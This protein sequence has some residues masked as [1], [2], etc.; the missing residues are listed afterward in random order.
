MFEEVYMEENAKKDPPKNAPEKATS[1]KKSPVTTII[2]IVA[3]VLLVIV[4]ISWWSC[5]TAANIFKKNISNLITST[6]ES[7]KTVTI[8]SDEGTETIAETSKW[9]SDMPSSVPELKSGKLTYAYK[10]TA[11]GKDTW[12]LTY[13]EINLS[14][15]ENYITQLKGL[16]WNETDR[17]DAGILLTIFLQKDNLKIN[18][19]FD[20]ESKGA[21]IS[22]Y[23]E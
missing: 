13:S 3:A 10:G 22:V 16:G 6:P 9:P 7:E 12:V 14:D 23:T 11:S 1:T 19:A 2:I 21:N 5:K 20:G 4:G 8:K 15:I 18:V 17:V